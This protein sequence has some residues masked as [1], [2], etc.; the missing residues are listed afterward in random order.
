[1]GNLTSKP[2]TDSELDKV[3]KARTEFND[4]L[5]NLQ[6]NT[7]ADIQNKVLTPETGKLIY[8]TIQDSNKWLKTNP[9]ANYS[10]VSTRRDDISKTIKIYIQTNAPKQQYYNTII[11]LPTIIQKLVDEKITTPEKQAAFLPILNAGKTWYTNNN[12][13]ATKTDLSQEM[14]KIRDNITTIFADSNVINILNNSINN[15]SNIQT[16]QLNT[17]L[18]N[19]QSQKTREDEQKI[20]AS[21]IGT[22][23]LETTLSVF[24]TLIIIAFFIFCGSLAANLAIARAPAY[25]I[26]YF[27]YG[28]IPIFSPFVIFYSILRAIS[29][30]G[31]RMYTILPL[32]IEPATTRL[33]KILW[34][35]FYWI[36]DSHAQ[37]QY[38]AYMASIPLQVA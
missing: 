2:P 26:L 27:I 30:E 14:Q 25:R 12:T 7:D 28:A 15:F 38:D 34:A 6:T 3:R 9:N 13:T 24:F 22:T 17:Q 37:A 35:P 1:M 32:S 31:M 18:A 23:I 5:D 29:K 20:D 11:A 33:G 36:P 4:Y 10:E 8:K 21:S 16:S 19:Y